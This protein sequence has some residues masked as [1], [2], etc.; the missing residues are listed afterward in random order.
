E[1]APGPRREALERPGGAAPPQRLRA[2]SCRR[3]VPG[4][5]RRGPL[6][7]AA[8][9]ARH[10]PRAR[11]RA[12]CAPARRAVSRP[13]ADDRG[14]GVRRARRDPRARPCSAPRRAARAAR[15]R[16][17]RPRTRA[18]ERRGAPDPRPGECRRHR[19]ACRRLL[20]MTLGLLNIDYQSLAD[21]TALGAVYALMAVGIGLVFGVLRLVNFAYGQLIM[22]GAFALALASPW[23]WPGLGGIVLLVGSVVVPAALTDPPVLA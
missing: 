17:L 10:S 23:G 5:Q 20:L 16:R 15:R 12:G 13:R 22:A 11:R 4:P 1:P 6:G 18:R 21:A 7:R 8:A 14:R 2:L 19:R 3:G 9:A